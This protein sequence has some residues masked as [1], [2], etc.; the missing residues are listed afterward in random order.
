MSTAVAT[1]LPGMPEPFSLCRRV[2]DGDTVVSFGPRVV[3]A[4]PSSDLGLRNL[5]VVALCN[6]GVKGIEVAEVFGLSPEYV[7][8]LRARAKDAGSTGL[9]RP[10]GAHR[11][12]SRA[13]LARVAKLARDGL[14]QAEIATRMSVSQPTIS[15][16]LG[17]VRCASAPGQLPLAN[18]TADSADERRSVNEDGVAHGVRPG[19]GTAEATEPAVLGTTPVARLGE[20]EVHSRYAGA[21]LL[22]AFLSATGTEDVLS[23]L[24]RITARRYDASGMLLAATFGFALGS[25]SIEGTKHLARPDAGALVGL[26]AFPELRTL[27]PRLAAIAEASDP[28]ALQG[29]FARAMLGA[30]DHPP[31]CYFVDDHFVTYTGASPVAKGWNTRKARA[32]RGRDDT[33]VVDD[34]WRAICFASGEPKGLSVNLPPVID[35]L[36]EI[37]GDRPIMVGFDRGGAYPKVFLALKER[38]VHW[39]TYRRAPLVAPQAD[40]K[41][42]WVNVDHRRISYRL[43]DEIVVLAGYGTARQLSVYEGATVAFQILTSDATTSGARLVRAL[44]ARWRIEN[45][46]KYAE[47]HHGIHWLCSYEMEEVA[48]DTLVDNPARTEARAK[49]KAASHAL[50]VAREVLGATV[51]HPSYP[52]ED[53]LTK[54]RDETDPVVMAEDDLEEATT[55]LAGIPAKLRRAEVHPGATRALPCLERR[56]FQMVC[57]LLAYNAELDLA[58]KLNTYLGDDNEYRGITRNLLHLG[59]VI[60]FSP[61]AIT[62]HLE[63]P[64]PPRLARALGLLVDEINL[65]A[66][67]LCGDGR[68]ITYVLAGATT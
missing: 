62:V 27:R 15:R 39:V 44:R 55:A 36:I 48:D 41:I 35:Q 21:M 5:A 29:A 52:I 46:F 16:A 65:T 24:P 8:R 67:R 23:G 22:H 38:N 28:L 59:G 68:T 58:R 10:R 18:S 2:I 40:R 12:L 31:E 54:M 19:G 64:D 6:A 50:V 56:A 45:T 4:F 14:T 33:F 7:S 25:A 60:D 30:D 32:E 11:K 49:R 26:G 3:F 1:E 47:A 37:C 9:A 66:P 57:R 63:R 34:S 13:E 43:A 17:Q 61:Q 51:A 53:H 42:S 20:A